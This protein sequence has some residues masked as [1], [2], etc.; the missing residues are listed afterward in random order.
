MCKKLAS[1]KSKQLDFSNF[2]P[3]FDKVL[4]YIITA[5][6]HKDLT[7]SASKL[8]EVKTHTTLAS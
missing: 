2:F 8:L 4:L 6:T 7:A 3:S 5:R 1:V